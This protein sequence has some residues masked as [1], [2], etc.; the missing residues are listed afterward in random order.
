MPSSLDIFSAHFLLHQHQPT[1]S[2]ENTAGIN[3]FTA[4]QSSRLECSSVMLPW[5]AGSFLSSPC[6]LPCS[7]LHSRHGRPQPCHPRSVA[8]LSALAPFLC[9]ILRV[10]VAYRV[11]RLWLFGAQPDF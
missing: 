2:P 6:F 11:F 3:G 10:R 1:Q 9:A 4:L 7:L 8:I 5:P